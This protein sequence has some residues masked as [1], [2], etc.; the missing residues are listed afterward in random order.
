[1]VPVELPQGFSIVFYRCLEGC[2]T[3]LFFL[4][5][6]GTSWVKMSNYG[7]LVWSFNLRVLNCHS[8]VNLP[9]NPIRSIR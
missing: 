1:M 6:M 7:N 8:N 9:S 4:Q 5:I 2:K 3:M